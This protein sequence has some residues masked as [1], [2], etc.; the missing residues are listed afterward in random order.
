MPATEAS[1][2]AWPA[3]LPAR[4]RRPFAA[5]WISLALHVAILALLRVEMPVTFDVG[6]GMIQVRL[7]P[8]RAT[9]SPVPPGEPSPPA[10]PD[11]PAPPR[12]P[13]V[14]QPEPKLAADDPPPAAAPV[15]APAPEPATPPAPT[16]PAAA[17]A[18]P[19]EGKPEPA[20]AAG[21]AAPE[22]T[23]PATLAIKSAV[24]LNYYSARE[25][26][27]QPRALRRI[28]PVYPPG[29]DRD[30]ISGR[31]RLQLKL[32]ADGRV[33]E[34]EVLTAE[35]PGLFEES[36]VKAFRQARFRPA[37]RAGRPVRA[38]MEIE[39]VYDWDGQRY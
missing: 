27:V 1:A 12:P 3:R 39:V 17:P 18:P 8:A 13:A 19:L 22:V 26:D 20:A 5:L 23:P 28:V 16:P 32:E 21:S 6:D 34:V 4:L 38:L 33:S 35:P 36:A 11:L 29:P 31:V 24:D 37:K 30:G 25:L 15:P 7:A 10:V 9:P 2:P 14:L